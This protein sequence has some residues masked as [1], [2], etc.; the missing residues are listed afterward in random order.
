MG[1]GLMVAVAG[2]FRRSLNVAR[3]GAAHSWHGV[4]LALLGWRATHSLEMLLWALVT[5]AMGLGIA[6]AV[7]LAR[8]RSVELAGS[9]RSSSRGVRAVQ[10]RSSSRLTAIA[11]IELATTR[12]SKSARVVMRLNSEL[13]SRSSM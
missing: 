13:R 2:S 7:A 1:F 12:A 5:V 3:Q 4:R 6:L 11:A 10:G 9:S 8:L